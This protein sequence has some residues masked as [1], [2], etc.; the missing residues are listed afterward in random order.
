MNN[1]KISLLNS[2]KNYKKLKKK[3]QKLQMTM[4]KIVNI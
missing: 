2:K 3:I 4:N 1:Y